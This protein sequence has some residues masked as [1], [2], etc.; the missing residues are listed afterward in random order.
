MERR[1]FLQLTGMSTAVSMLAGC[2]KGN[3]KLIPFLIPPEDGS[4]PGTANYYASSCRQCPAGCGI[5]VRVSEGRAKKVEGNPRHPLNQGKLCARGQALVQDLYHPDRIRQPLKRTGPRG[6]GQYAP[7][8]WDEGLQVLAEKL[9]V[10]QQAGRQQ[11]MALLTAPMRGSMASLT[12]DFLATFGGGKHLAWD[13]L[14]PEWRQQG[15]FGNQGSRKYDI[16]NSQYLMSFGA[17]FLETHQS[18][19]HYGL[20]FGRM[21]QARPTIRGRFTYLGPRLSM[22]A[23]SADRWLPA[24]PG[25]EWVMALGIIRHILQKNLQ[26]TTSLTKLGL[27][28][29]SITQLVAD[30][31]ARKIAALSGINLADVEAALEEASSIRPALAIPGEMMAWQTNGAAATAAVDLLNLVLGNINQPGGLLFYPVTTAQRISPYSDLLTMI[32]NM[33]QGQVSLAMI[34]GVNPLYNLPPAMGFQHALDK[35]PSIISFAT[36]LDDTTLQA[37]LILPDHSNLESWGDSIPVEGVAPSVFGL[38]QPVVK[39]LYDT[40]AF[41]DVLLALSNTLD[42]DSA[43]G[44]DLNYQ[45]WLENYLAEQIPAAANV[46]FQSFR[47]KL[48]QQGG[49]FETE[50]QTVSLPQFKL[51]QEPELPSFSTA[52]QAFPLHLQI[53]PSPVYY[54]GR[55]SHL[56]WLQQ[57]PDPMTTAVWGSWLELNPQTAARLGIADGDLVEVRSAQGKIEL[58][59]VLYPGIRP[60]LVACPMGQGHRGQGRFASERGINPMNLLSVSNIHGSA[61]PVWGNTKVQLRRISAAGKLTTAGDLK[62]S[63]RQELLGL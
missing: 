8:S 16:E 56:P 5:L 11:E 33:D 42:P 40:R 38:I 10:M 35:V 22:T 18:P 45:Q 24:R 61:L 1:T 50:G 25:T 59:A 17:D 60:D 27:S 21:R 44:E 52:E 51:P 36:M 19:V 28:L 30:Y 37:D 4:K 15:L 63:Y 46:N 43:A 26:D 14:H 2:R 55:S 39:S 29:A 57:L 62:G 54:D 13:P 20:T 23:A 58:P 31:D 53:Y 49:W 48:F 47:D 34:H 3:E 6:S 41:A 7:I 12:A 9:T 32:D